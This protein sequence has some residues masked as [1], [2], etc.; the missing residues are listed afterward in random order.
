MI[1]I[2]EKPTV[3]CPG[4]SS[5]FIEFEYKREIVDCIKNSGDIAVY[6]KKSKIWECPVTSLSRLIESLS[7]YEDIEL[8][9]MEDCKE[10]IVKDI[11][12][13]TNNYITQPYKYQVNSIKY[14][15]QHDKWLL[16]DAPGLGKTLQMLYL[17]QELKNRKNIEHCLIIC[18]VNTLKN[19]W[20]NEILKHTNLSCRILG[21]KVSS[22]G[23]VSIGSVSERVEQLKNKLNEFFII[24]NIE[25]L[26]N[27]DIVKYI[28]N[29][30]NNFDMI[31][32]DEAHTCFDG[33]TQVLV[34]GEVHTIKE[35]VENNIGNC[36]LSHDFNTGTDVYKSIDY[37]HSYNYTGRIITFHIQQEDGK[38][39][40]LKVTPDHL[41]YTHNRGYVKAIDITKEDTI[42]VR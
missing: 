36:I 18:G 28:E 27:D 33:S 17:A 42:E 25:T 12:L 4:L 24:T 6:D 11:A 37:R 40:E 41:I 16:L 22:K 38:E 30:P 34:D 32:L 14:G 8:T 15:L 5:L 26:R 21:E 29:G 2:T 9:L 13:N 31:V 20:K 3:K 1:S 39:I 7:N 23:K 10:D 35:V 19:N